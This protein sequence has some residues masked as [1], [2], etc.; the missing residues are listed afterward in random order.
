MKKIG[1]NHSV[2]SKLDVL[3]KAQDI[4]EEI[5]VSGL[6]T[7]AAAIAA[8]GAA[9]DDLLL[10]ALPLVLCAAPP[11]VLDAAAAGASAGAQPTSIGRFD[12]ITV[13]DLRGCLLAGS[14]AGEAAGVAD[15]GVAGRLTAALPPVLC[16]PA[17]SHMDGVAGAQP[18]SIECRRMDGTASV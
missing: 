16:L 11:A 13:V 15:E 17:A 9:A 6:E 8:A 2:V 10:A 1:E 5:V 7:S 12:G 14:V 18:T 3:S 4:L